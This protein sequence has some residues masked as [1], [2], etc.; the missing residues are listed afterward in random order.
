[1][2]RE[3]LRATL[4]T[5]NK[6]GYLRCH[7]D[8]VPMVLLAAVGQAMVDSGVRPLVPVPLEMVMAAFETVAGPSARGLAP[9][10]RVGSA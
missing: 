5:D 7:R 9:L 4:A 10:E 8:E 6:R 1:M 2:D 3:L